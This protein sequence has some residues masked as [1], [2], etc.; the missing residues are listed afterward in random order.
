MKFDAD[1]IVPLY[2][3]VADELTRAISAGVYR[4]GDQVPSTTEISREY[5]L[6]PATV[7][8]GMNILVGNGLLEKRRGLGMFVTTGAPAQL[9]RELKQ[10]FFA[11]QLPELVRAAQELGISRQELID[12][13]MNQEQ[14]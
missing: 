7:L 11:K 1:S 10:E 13:L 2:Q 9:H 5:Q 14:S 12:A 4:A 8:K 6:N 3:Q